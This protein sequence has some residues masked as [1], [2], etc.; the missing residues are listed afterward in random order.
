MKRSEIVTDVPN[1]EQLKTT[2]LKLVNE[3]GPEKTIC[4]SEVARKLGEDSD[5]KKLMHPVHKAARELHKSGQVQIEQ[6]GEPVDPDQCRGP[7]RLRVIPK[8][9]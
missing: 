8:D 7:I 2:I 5:W 9:E 6:Q 3:R 4:P 1:I